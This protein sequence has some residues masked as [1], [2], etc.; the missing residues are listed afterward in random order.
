MRGSMTGRCT[1][2]SA[3][4]HDARGLRRTTP[5]RGGSLL[6]TMTDSHRLVLADLPTYSDRVV[7]FTDNSSS[8]CAGGRLNRSDSCV[9]ISSAVRSLHRTLTPSPPACETRPNGTAIAL[10]DIASK[11]RARSF[12]L[13]GF[14][15]C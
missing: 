13:T 9:V 12:Q 3:L 15:K 1:S 5:A 11:I 2:Q 10:H 4:C 14:V 6:L 8:Q 7:V